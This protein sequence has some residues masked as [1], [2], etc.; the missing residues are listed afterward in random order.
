MHAHT[1][2]DKYI[3]IFRQG[4]NNRVA[5]EDCIEKVCTPLHLLLFVCFFKSLENLLTVYCTR[6]LY[7]IQWHVIFQR[8]IVKQKPTTITSKT[9]ARRERLAIEENQREKKNEW[10]K[11]GK[12]K[13]NRFSC[14]YCSHTVMWI[15]YCGVCVRALLIYEAIEGMVYHTHTHTQ[16]QRKPRGLGLR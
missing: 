8:T 4:S 6:T 14:S 9:T 10:E 1:N 15:Y 16:Q 12:A 5:F 3:Y 2:S 7:S 11:S 13:I